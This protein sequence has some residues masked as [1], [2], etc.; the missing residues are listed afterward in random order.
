[1]KYLNIFTRHI[2]CSLLG[3]TTTIAGGYSRKIGKTD[4]PAQNASFSNDFELVYMHKKCALLVVDRGNR[5]IRQ[6]NLNS[7]D[8]AREKPQSGIL[9]SYSIDC[10]TKT[11]N[12][13][14]TFGS[15]Q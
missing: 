6:I 4:G 7:K 8:C 12:D 3:F 15:F 1:M 13:I 14:I 2:F 11:R 9:I 10:D 5:L